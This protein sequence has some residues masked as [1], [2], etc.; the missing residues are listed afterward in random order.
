MVRGFTTIE[1]P[2]SSCE[3]CILTKRY[4]EAFSISTY[5]AKE[6]LEYFIHKQ[7]SETFKVFKNFKTMVEK[8]SGMFIQILRYEQGGEYK[9]NEFME[10]SIHQ[11]INSH[12]TTRYTP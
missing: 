3:R 5:P 9:L 11:G 4:R 7:K 12:F 6:P 8:K 1:Q 2:T 10:F